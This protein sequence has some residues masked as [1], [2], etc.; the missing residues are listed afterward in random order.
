MLR[1][2]QEY[3][4]ILKA[5]FT[6]DEICDHIDEIDLQAL[7]Y[8]GYRYILLDVDNTLLT[9]DQRNVT[10]QRINWI[11][12]LKS[13]GFNV[14]LV[15][16]NLRYQRIQR[17]CKQLNINYALYFSL[18][19]FVFSIKDFAETHGI[20]LK[21][22]I[23]IGDQL[24]TDVI[25]GNWLRCYTVLVDPLDKQLSFL[26]TMQREIELFLLKKLNIE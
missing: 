24:F 14:Y 1:I 23:V 21:K 2:F 11:E 13:M 18:K 26:K 4:D 25:M 10:L 16:N 22:S 9:Y 5:L 8:K 17:V 19:P 15:S 20:N 7:Y 3:L 12:N 6:P